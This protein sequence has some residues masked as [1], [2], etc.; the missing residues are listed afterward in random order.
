MPKSSRGIAMSED[1]L[2]AELRDAIAKVGIRISNAK[3]RFAKAVADLTKETLDR[4]R[5]CET[6]HATN[7]EK[8]ATL[9]R[10]SSAQ[11]ANINELRD[12][13]ATTA[14]R[15]EA[16]EKDLRGQCDDLCDR[17]TA[18]EGSEKERDVVLTKMKLSLGENRL[19][20]NILWAAA[21]FLCGLVGTGAGK[22]IEKLM[23]SVP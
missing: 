9:E 2:R 3:G 4:F 19:R 21:I 13:K 14:G 10:S 20:T 11:W 6:R 8:I 12:W 7:T 23:A 16:T 18:I 17:V 15:L 1:T 5:E 22:F